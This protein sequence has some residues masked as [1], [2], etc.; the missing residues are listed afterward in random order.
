MSSSV[1]RFRTAVTPF[2]RANWSTSRGI[3]SGR[4]VT[5]RSVRFP[6]ASN[7]TRTAPR[8][9]SAA[10]GGD[11][12]ITRELRCSENGCGPGG[13]LVRSA[14]GSAPQ[15][16]VIDENPNGVLSDRDPCCASAVS[17]SENEAPNR[18]MTTNEGADTINEVRR[19]VLLAMA[20]VVVLLVRHSVHA[21]EGDTAPHRLVPQSARGVRGAAAPY[22]STDIRSGKRRFRLELPTVILTDVPVGRVEVQAIDER[23]LPDESFHGRAKITGIVILQDGRMR[24]LPAFQ[25]GRLV[26]TSDLAAGPKVYV[27]APRIRVEHSGFT[28]LDQP[29]RRLWRWLSL[30]PPVVAIVLAVWWRSVLPA[31]LT[32][33][34]VGAVVI[35]FGNPLHGAWLT[36]KDF[37]VFQLFEP[38]EAEK[39]HAVI[40]LFTLFLGALIGVMARS[41]GTGELVRRLSRHAHTR[42]RGQLLTCVM[43]LV[44]FFDDYANTLLLGGTL[45]PVADRLRI[46]REKLAFLVDS[47]AAPVSGLAIISTWI[48]FEIGQIS[49]AFVNVGLEANAFSVFVRTIPY[50]FYALYLLVFVW[51]IAATGRDYGPMLRAERIALRTP[52]PDPVSGTTP[53]G[54]LRQTPPG[55]ARPPRD[56]VCTALIPLA[57][58]IGLLLLGLWWSGT[59]HLVSEN[60]RRHQAGQPLLKA[61]LLTVLQFAAANRVLLVASFSASVTAIL[62][63]R[64]TGTLGWRA[65][66]RAWLEGAANMRMAL[67]ILVLAWGVASVCDHEHLNTAGVVVE[68]TQG[69][70]EPHW[71]PAMSFL[72]AAVVS[73]ATGSSF[74][75]MGLLIPLFVAVT[76]H[77]LAG[78]GTVTAD[79]PLMLA[80]IGAVLAGAIFGD[81]CSPISDTTILSSAA[82]GCDHLRHVATQIPYAISVATVALLFGYLPA[83]W[84]VA[85]LSLIPWGCL[86]LAALVWRFGRLAE[87]VP[88]EA[89]SVRPGPSSPELE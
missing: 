73:F 47:T 19:T 69:L 26:L 15:R 6:S 65:A 22:A 38:G 37:V 46:S 39:D 44:V 52:P 60:A 63:A 9:R 31:L 74:S 82:S 84:H 21:S 78:T 23:G 1:C 64:A 14:T 2:S 51:L 24:P 50:R 43:G 53:E 85:P 55:A 49:A 20:L 87:A 25:R 67:A 17:G 28:S 79:H 3:S 56:C 10:R 11:N 12:D 8:L 13:W 54:P 5:A 45:R 16:S 30:L 62:C 34:W 35:A 40:V 57:V 42:Q 83:G 59:H 88:A 4:A 80:T 76:Y 58:L 72:I 77:L 29:V 66:G 89:V 36:V 7:W 41:G 33:I 61:G 81:H 75:T 32:A 86:T 48:G 27:T 18:Q 70:L 71:M 68:L